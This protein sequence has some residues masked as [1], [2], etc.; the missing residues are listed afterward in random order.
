[1]MWRYDNAYIT[2]SANQDAFRDVASATSAAP[3]K[4]CKRP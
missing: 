2:K 1:M 4:S 3:R